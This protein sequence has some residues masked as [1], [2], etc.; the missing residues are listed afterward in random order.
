MMLSPPA[1]SF[2]VY[3]ASAE[4]AET[5]RSRIEEVIYTEGRIGEVTTYCP[6][7]KILEERRIT[8][9]PAV[10]RVHRSSL[11]E[12]VWQGA[13]PSRTEILEWIRLLP[14]RAPYES[15]IEE[16]RRQIA[17]QR[18][19][20]PRTLDEAVQRLLCELSE[21]DK[22]LLVETLEEELIKYHHGWGTGIR[23]AWLHGNGEL[24]ESCGAWELDEASQ[25][26]IR[27]VWS[28]LKSS[29]EN[30]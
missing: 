8:S 6:S 17:E 10:L 18:L 13:D 28:A 16:T 11:Y 1:Y 26:I 21:E 14:D 24:L 9:L 30:S 2:V 25:V 3:G 22:H 20:A 29:K 5:L 4:E 15:E 27:G 7:E 12:I 19:N 23:N